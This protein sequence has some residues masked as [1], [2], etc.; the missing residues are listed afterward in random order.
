MKMSMWL[1]EI[2]SPVNCQSDHRKLNEK[3]VQSKVNSKSISQIALEQLNSIGIKSNK[4]KGVMKAQENSQIESNRSSNDVS[5]QRKNEDGG[6]CIISEMSNATSKHQGNWQD[7][8]VTSDR[9]NVNEKYEFGDG[10]ENSQAHTERSSKAGCNWEDSQLDYL[11]E[12]KT[13]GSLEKSKNCTEGTS[14]AGGS[15]EDSQLGQFYG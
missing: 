15:L 11:E 3:T 6:S 14:K 4:L 2:E 7:S 9:T 1:K 12:S 13:K 5:I 8:Q 10:R